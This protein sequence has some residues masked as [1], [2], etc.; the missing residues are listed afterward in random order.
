MNFLLEKTKGML[1]KTLDKKNKKNFEQFVYS[2]CVTFVNS[3]YFDS[4]SE[5]NTNLLL[6]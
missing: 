3:I 6:S 5:F 1:E 4:S 2:Y